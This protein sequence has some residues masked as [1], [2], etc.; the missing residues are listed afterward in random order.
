MKF[1]RKIFKTLILFTRKNKFGFI[2]ISNLS[3]NE[4]YSKASMLIESGS[5]F[6]VSRFEKKFADIIG[7][8]Y[9]KS[10]SAGRMGFYVLMKVLNI[11][12]EDEVI[13][14]SGNCS[15]MVNAILAIGA[16]PVYSDVDL[17]TFGSCPYE[18]E[19]QITLKTKMIVAQH[20]FGIPCK[21]DKIKDI[22]NKNRIFLL[23]DC[24]LTLESRF[25]KIKVGNFGDASLFS[26]DHT[27]P[28][29][30][31]SGGA[32][33]TSQKILFE[34]L[35]LA[36]QEIINLS[37][38]KQK[39][40]LRRHFLEQRLI[41]SNNYKQLKIFD[42][43]NSISKRFSFMTPYLDE[44]TGINN[45]GCSY[46]YPSKMPTFI[47]HILCNHIDKT[48]YKLKKLRERNL[49]V[50]IKEL[51]STKLGK[52]IPQ[53]YFDKK[54]EIVPLR[55]ILFNS[56]MNYDLKKM[57]YSLIN[58]DEIWFQTPIISTNLSSSD[59]GLNEKELT[60]SVELGNHIIN[61]PLD[62][63]EKS[64]NELIHRLKILIKNNA[65]LIH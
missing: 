56:K 19:K 18:I 40:M 11:G 59:F 3:S 62:L 50:L 38:K 52:F 6:E 2:S 45:I 63:N 55:L 41:I 17:D 31:F 23:E 4:E 9:V 53:I 5:N 28:L 16:K 26:F 51:N 54:N 14:N 22:A 34:K 49:R 13:V 47:A 36:D 35:Q 20:S 64:L 12:K 1:L 44:N 33:Y 39:A 29:N 61:L 27:K 57:F 58:T 21:I 48:W 30:G 37:K 24:A 15:V 32:I 10:Y 46:P 42:L 25:N 8:G 7:D 65:H 43:I 60:K